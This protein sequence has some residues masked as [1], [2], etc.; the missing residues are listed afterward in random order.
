VSNQ[1]EAASPAA[2]TENPPR[3]KTAWQP[4]SAR[5]LAAFGQAGF[6]RT[7]LWLGLVALL[8]TGTVIWFLNEAWF[9]A[10]RAAIHELPEQGEIVR[11][12]L[13]TP[14]A[15]SRSLAEQRFLGFTLLGSDAPG[16]DLSSHIVVRF[17]KKS[18]EACSLFGCSRWNY[19]ADLQMP[20]NRIDSQA[21]WE[22]WQPFLN[23]GAA[24]GVVAGLLI[25]WTTLGVAYSL[26]AWPIAWILKKNVTWGGTVRIACAAQML[27]SLLLLAG[28]WGY[29]LRLIDLVQLLS[30]ALLQLFVAWIYVGCALKVVPQR[31]PPAEKRTN[32]FAISTGA[33]SE[34]SKQ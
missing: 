8:G 1:V 2:S 6:G 13:N 5:G 24:L 32:P 11:G 19:S 30:L 4:F 33:T 23:G 26:V 18:V 14:A 22:A 28:I 17:R 12:T 3:P 10:V 25:F 16:M 27:G 20:F 7:F 15:N 31:T 34:L 29:G 9:P 21:K